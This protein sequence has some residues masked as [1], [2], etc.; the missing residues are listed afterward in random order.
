MCYIVAKRIDTEGCVA[1][2]TEHGQH[3]V[4]FKNKL[5]NIVGYER[6]QLL[7]ISSPS[8]YGEYE[9]YCIVDSEYEFEAAVRKMQ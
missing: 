4:D 6:V 8:A 7:T 3:L 5:I 9:P 2:R 1:L